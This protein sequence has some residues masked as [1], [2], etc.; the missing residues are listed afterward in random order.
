[1]TALLFLVPPSVLLMCSCLL[2]SRFLDSKQERVYQRPTEMGAQSRFEA[3]RIKVKKKKGSC[4]EEGQRTVELRKFVR[5]TQSPQSRKS[6]VILSRRFALP[7]L[8]PS[9]SFYKRVT[10]W[11][12]M[13]G[14]FSF[15]VVNL[16]KKK[17]HAC[18]LLSYYHHLHHGDK[19]YDNH[20]KWDLDVLSPSPSFLLPNGIGICWNAN[21]RVVAIN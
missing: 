11:G 19:S 6:S 13:I 20:E 2:E 21:Y 12:G 4:V 17:V 18:V 7:L 10:L 15:R 8:T 16:Y 3:C 5:K 1:M 14:V 9:P